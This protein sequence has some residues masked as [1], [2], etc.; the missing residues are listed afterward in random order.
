MVPCPLAFV[1]KQC[2]IIFC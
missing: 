2:S 1:V